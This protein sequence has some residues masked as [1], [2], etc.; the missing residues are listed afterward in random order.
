MINTAAH[1]HRPQHQRP[2]SQLG[3]VQHVIHKALHV[4]GA[5]LDSAN[6]LAL[7]A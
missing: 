3:Q 7:A 4:E 1:L 2:L 6:V 5:Q